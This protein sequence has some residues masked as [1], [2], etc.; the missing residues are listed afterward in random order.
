MLRPGIKHDPRYFL[1]FLISV[2]ALLLACRTVDLIANAQ[3]TPT[4]A[5]VTRAAQRATFTPLPTDTD[6]PL[7][8]DTPEPTETPQPTDTP[9][10]TRRPPTRRPPTAAPPTHPPPTARPPTPIPTPTVILPW[11]INGSVSC[12]GGSDNASTV[13]GTIT[14]NNGP[15]V[16]QRVQ[17]SA[18][19]GGEPI[20][21]VPA[22]SNSNGVY[23]VTF[24]CNGGACNGDFWVW[25]VDAQGH[26]ISP[27]QKF[28]FNNNCRK[29]T[30]NFKKR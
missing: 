2:S 16:G 20:S 12:T 10:P 18:G 7:P 9:E 1:V 27:F 3:A 22:M 19:P 21:D 26:Q 25:M 11:Y 14:T 6:T 17:G 24:I 13:T 15:A 4:R 29:G 30:V 8:T 5:R 23:K 28:S